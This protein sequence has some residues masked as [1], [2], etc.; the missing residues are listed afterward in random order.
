MAYLLES[1]F[2]LSCFYA[3]YWLFLRK[4][5]FFH[6]NRWYLL[7][8]PVFSFLIPALHIQLEKP[9]HHSAAPL[10]LPTLVVQSQVAPQLLHQ[11][12]QQPLPIEHGITL[13][14]LMGIIYNIGVALLAFVLLYRLFRLVRFIRSCRITQTDTYQVA[15]SAQGETPVASFFSLVFWNKS[16]INENDRLII[17]HELVHARQWHSLDVLLME[18]LVVWQW[19][20]PLIYLYRRSLQVV[21][22]YIADEY[23]VRQTQQRYAYASLLAQQYRDRAHPDLMNTF[24]AQLKN[25][26]IMLAKNPSPRL[27]KVYYGLSFPIALCLMVLFSFRL[28]DNPLSNVIQKADTYA[29]ELA[30]ITVNAHLLDKITA[31]DRS[32]PYIF[33]WGL[34]QTNIEYDN[35]NNQYFGT[36][37]TSYNTLSECVRREPRLWNGTTLEPELRFRFLE[38]EMGSR[39]GDRTAYASA[40]A[41]LDSLSYEQ[42]KNQ[43]LKIEKIRFPDGKYG[44][45][46]LIL[47]EED[48]KWLLRRSL[49]N[50]GNAD[51]FAWQG[52]TYIQWGNKQYTPAF[53][54]YC[55][56]KQLFDLIQ[57]KPHFVLSDGHVLQSDEFAVRAVRNNS[58][59]L[60]SRDVKTS[61]W[62]TYAEVL[63]KLDWVRGSMV[64]GTVLYMY[65]N[66]GKG[67]SEI[68]VFTLVDENDDR[69]NQNA[70]ELA[71]YYLNW[72]NSGVFARFPQGYTT[73]YFEHFG[74]KDTVYYLNAGQRFGIEGFE[75]T[76]DDLISSFSQPIVLKKNDKVLTD[77]HFDLSYLDK[78]MTVN[79]GE[80]TTAQ[81]AWLKANLKPKTMLKLHHFSGKSFDL[82]KVYLNVDIVSEQEKAETPKS[83]L[84]SVVKALER[85]MDPIP[86]LCG[87]RSSILLLQDIVSCTGLELRKPD[88]QVSTAYEITSYEV[89][90][91][92]KNQDPITMNM[93]QAQFTSELKAR[94]KEILSNG[95]SLFFDNIVV[96]KIGTQEVR[97]IGGIAFKIK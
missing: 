43:T 46:T 4:T 8:T 72:G 75:K 49:T 67:G 78:T 22:E 56:A 59:F 29:Q 18:G 83:E 9:Q 58:S 47:D 6:W 1:A 87:F 20:N 11:Q 26:L 33:Y 42:Y 32:T 61:G 60:D 86:T 91:L 38:Q 70:S 3:F 68:A 76:P 14:V 10:D 51:P 97:N 52:G 2:C 84:E 37:H 19:F 80:L 50:P 82:N 94:I 54:Q 30:E 39:V 53:R 95:G 79:N 96:R 31:D 69:L 35:V 16:E 63:T 57:D 44:T 55:T 73:E 36:I 92:A 77:Y 21:H 24:H 13:G 17:E 89:T 12:L 71:D 64:K 74:G 34:V 15:Q 65:A 27:Q 66:I 48:P 90:L 81:Q 40:R 5:T 23:V 88:D 85:K 41:M 62:Q 93:Y 7:S 25:R 45:V 28:M